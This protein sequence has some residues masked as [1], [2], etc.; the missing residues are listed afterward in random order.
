MES[1]QTTEA[2]AKH[3]SLTRHARLY[4]THRASAAWIIGGNELCTINKPYLHSIII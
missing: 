2:P 1:K 4:S 3:F